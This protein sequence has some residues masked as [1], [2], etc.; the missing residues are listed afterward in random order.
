MS[1]IE[2]INSELKKLGFKIDGD[3]YTYTKTS[4]STII[5]N[6]RP[7]QQEHKQVLNMKYIGDGCELDDSDNEIEGSELCGF[8]ILDEGHSV[9]TIF[10]SCV[11]DFL[12]F[13]NL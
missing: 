12:S 1:K 6:G 10:V 5:Y 7:M 3:D 2:S 8:D 4:Y 9:T 11:D 13:I